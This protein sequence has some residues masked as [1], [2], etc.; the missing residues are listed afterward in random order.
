MSVHPSGPHTSPSHCSELNLPRPDTDTHRDL[1]GTV[2]DMFASKTDTDH[3]LAGLRRRVKDVEGTILVF[4]HVHI[5]FGPLRS[6]DTAGHFAF[7][8]SL[9]INC[10]NRLFTNLDGWTDASTFERAETSV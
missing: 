4:H 9:C 1:E 8:S 3:I 2:W 10:D 6:T 7:P 5:E